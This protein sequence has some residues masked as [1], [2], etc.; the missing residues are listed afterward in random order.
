MMQYPVQDPSFEYK[1][2]GDIVK[3][4]PRMYQIME[5]YFGQDCLK[6]PGFKIQTLE[7]ACILFDIDQ[8]RLLQEFEEIQN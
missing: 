2:T 1:L 8:R 6:K 4:Y 3:K 7:I 5:R